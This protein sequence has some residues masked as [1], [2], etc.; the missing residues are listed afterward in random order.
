M[1]DI[2][3]RARSLRVSYRL[4]QDELAERSGASLGSIKRFEHTGKIALESL[5]K[6]AFILEAMDGVGKLF[7]VKNEPS[8]KSL[9]ALII[10][11]LTRL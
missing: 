10:T 7:L 9:D 8:V 3:R 6:I 11:L 1:E 2:A 5:L 4:T